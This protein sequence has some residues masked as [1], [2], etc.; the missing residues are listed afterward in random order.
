M[1]SGWAPRHGEALVKD[2][3]LAV[4]RPRG[5]PHVTARPAFATCVV[6]TSSGLC[7]IFADISNVV[8]WQ[9]RRVDFYARAGRKIARNARGSVDGDELCVVARIGVRHAIRQRLLRRHAIGHHV[10]V[11]AHPFRTSAKISALS[12]FLD[13][14]AVGTNEI[15]VGQLKTLPTSMAKRESVPADR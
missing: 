3:V 9:R 2:D 15:N 12:D 14:G 8:S 10:T 11:V 6:D 7:P 4:R 13:S 5:R 1:F